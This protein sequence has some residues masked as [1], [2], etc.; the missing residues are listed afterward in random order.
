MCSDIAQINVLPLI[1]DF[2]VLVLSTLFSHEC[3][4][5]KLSSEGAPVQGVK[6][7]SQTGLVCP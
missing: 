2:P 5:N 3:S 7:C 1:L 6:G 4:F